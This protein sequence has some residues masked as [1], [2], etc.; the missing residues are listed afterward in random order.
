MPLRVGLYVASPHY[1]PGFSLLSLTLNVLGEYYRGA[2]GLRPFPLRGSHTALPHA[3]HFVALRFAALRAGLCVIRSSAFFA[4]LLKKTCMQ[5]LRKFR[6]APP[7]HC[8]SHGV[9][10][11]TPPIP[12]LLCFFRVGS[13]SLRSLLLCTPKPPKGC[14]LSVAGVCLGVHRSLCFCGHCVSPPAALSAR[15]AALPF[16]AAATRCEKLGA[17]R[18]VA[19]AT[20]RVSPPAPPGGSARSLPPPSSFLVGILSARRACPPTPAPLASL[21]Y[22]Y[23][24]GVC[25]RPPLD[26]YAHGVSTN[27]LKK[28]K[29]A[30]KLP[31]CLLPARVKCTPLRY[32]LAF[33]A[34]LVGFTLL[35]F[36]FFLFGY[37]FFRALSAFFR[38]RSVRHCG[39]FGVSFF[40]SSCCFVGFC[41]CCRSCF[42][43]CFGWL[44]PWLRFVRSGCFPFCGCLFCF[45]FR[46]WSWGFRCSFCCF[47]SV[48][49]CFPFARVCVFSFGCVSALVGS[50]FFPFSLL[51][52]SWF[53]VL[54]FLG[55][56][57]WSWRALLRLAS[58]WGGSSSALGL[59]FSWWWLVFSLVCFSFFIHSLWFLFKISF[60]VLTPRKRQP[61]PIC[62]SCSLPLPFVLK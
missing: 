7:L 18:E 2:S 13:N 22:A 43:F 20:L 33:T 37:G 60:V 31:T 30:A 38:P 53:G 6:C 10:V 55:S 4:S 42:R 49:C 25:A 41:F 54:G 5:G 39:L 57:C 56:C 8:T 62:A 14:S 48:A 27:N 34:S 40:R 29:K 3:A 11:E 24:A 15:V 35:S 45:F 12:P 23:S 32:A 9:G 19:G 26:F 21:L 50:F 46:V 16:G 58:C 28:T 44:R 47:G 61:S 1:V 36:F 51:F 52:G 17:K 59:R